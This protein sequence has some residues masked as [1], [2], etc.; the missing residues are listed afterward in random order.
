MTIKGVL[1]TNIISPVPGS[2]LTIRLGTDV[3]DPTKDGIFEIQNASGSGVLAVDQ[4]GNLTASGS[5]FFKE[6]ASNLFNIVRGAQA[7]TSVTETTASASA[8][9]AVIKRYYT[10]RTI[11]S[12]YVSE[13][14]L[15]YV[16]ATSDTQGQTPY[17][18]RQTAEDPGTGT[19]GSFTIQIPTTVSQDIKINWWIVN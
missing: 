19:K 7:D 3:S 9:T 5:G 17:I 8:G 15:I 6:V 16:T 4:K 14:S 1:A 13:K 12:P 2:N 10:E 18:A 11:F